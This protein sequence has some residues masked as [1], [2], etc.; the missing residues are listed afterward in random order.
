[1]PNAGHFAVFLKGHLLD[2]GIA[3]QGKLRDRL[4]N[5]ELRN[6][7]GHVDQLRDLPIIQ[8]TVDHRD[9]RVGVRH[10]QLERRATRERVGFNRCEGIGQSQAFKAVA[11]GKSIP[12]NAHKPSRKL[13]ARQFSAIHEH[14]ARN[15][16]DAVGNRDTCQAATSEEGTGSDICE[17][18]RK[19]NACQTATVQ[20]R[21]VSYTRNSVGNYDTRQII[22]IKEGH[23]A[24]TR[25]APGNRDAGQGVATGKSPLV[26]ARKS[27][28][29]DDITHAPHL[30]DFVRMSLDIRRERHR[31]IRAQ[32]GN[33]LVF[34][35]F[36]HEAE[37]VS[38]IHVRKA[39]GLVPIRCISVSIHD[40]LGV[41][42]NVTVVAT[43]DLQ[44]QTT[45]VINCIQVIA[46]VKRK[47]V[48]ARDIL[49]KGDACKTTTS[50]KYRASNAD[51]IIRESDVR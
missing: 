14:I 8:N 18:V 49:R 28:G 35:V 15:T 3:F 12:A 36:L 7:I 24:N 47:I 41:S 22:A 50:I 23:T 21:I 17:A 40:Q 2:R 11:T 37:A 16:R 4:G 27:I 19:R 29:D 33:Q 1:M 31:F 43:A 20:E 6:R 48:N 25:D 44:I 32:I 26:N 5:A 34:S 30:I 45:V 46:R 9:I 10:R 13:N 38:R 51:E 39:G 42:G